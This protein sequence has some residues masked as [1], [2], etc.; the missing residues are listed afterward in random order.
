[1]FCRNA[2]YQ[3]SMFDPLNKMPK[4]LKD[5]LKKSWSHVFREYIFPKIKE[6]RFKILYSDNPATRPNSPVNVIIGL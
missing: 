2:H 1:M 3:I 6:E 4:Y 5:I